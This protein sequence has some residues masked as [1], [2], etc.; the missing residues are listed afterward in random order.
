VGRLTSPPLPQSPHKPMQPHRRQVRFWAG[1]SRSLGEWNSRPASDLRSVSPSNPRHG[2]L[3]AH[4]RAFAT[5]VFRALPR[6]IFRLHDGKQRIIALRRIETEKCVSPVRCVKNP[7]KPG[8]SCESAWVSGALASVSDAL[9]ESRKNREKSEFTNETNDANAHS[10]TCSTGRFEDWWWAEDPVLWGRL[11]S[12]LIAVPDGVDH[13]HL[14]SQRATRHNQQRHK[15]S[16]ASGN[17]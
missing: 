10:R 17:R 2:P 1:L 14:T 16:K 3:A 4:P 5:L 15:A 11:S 8:V 7:P 13:G 9:E 12:C 6:Y